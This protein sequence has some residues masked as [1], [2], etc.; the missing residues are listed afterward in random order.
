MVHVQTHFC[1]ES[2]GSKIMLNRTEPIQHI[3]GANWP[4]NIWA[5]KDDT[6]RIAKERLGDA[7]L[8]LFFGFHA[9]DAVPG[10]SFGGV[11]Y[12]GT[13]CSYF[14]KEWQQALTMWAFDPPRTAGVSKSE[15]YHINNLKYKD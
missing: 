12:V 2:L 6:A 7:N 15:N 10:P 11:A 13:A 1:H 14:V 5:Y 4:A 9:N 8:A 3:P